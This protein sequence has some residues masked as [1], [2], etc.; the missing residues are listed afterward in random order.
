[1]KMKNDKNVV[2]QSFPLLIF[3]RWS[4]VW[5]P[6]SYMFFFCFSLQI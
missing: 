2:I 5:E 4:K 3:T 1:M 6:E